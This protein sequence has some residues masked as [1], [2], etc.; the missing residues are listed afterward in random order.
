MVTVTPDR[1][2]ETGQY[3]PEYPLES[4]LEAVEELHTATTAKVATKVDC[5]Y[6]LAYRRLH[7][8][9]EQ[10]ALTKEEVGGSFVWKIR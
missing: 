5:S 2:D 10:G 7:D 3:S 8:L 4:F 9:E 1:D 6:D